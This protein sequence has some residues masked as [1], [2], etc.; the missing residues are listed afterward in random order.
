MEVYATQHRLLTAGSRVYAAPLRRALSGMYMSRWRSY[1]DVIGKV[2]D[3]LVVFEAQAAG[4]RVWHVLVDPRGISVEE[5]PVVAL[6][7]PPPGS[8]PQCLDADSR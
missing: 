2:V 3:N 5:V 8:T 4:A 7:L 1:L 6:R